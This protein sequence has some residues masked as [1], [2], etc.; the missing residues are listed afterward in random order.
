MEHIVIEPLMHWMCQC[1]F[2]SVHVLD[3]AVYHVAEIWTKIYTAIVQFPCDSMALVLFYYCLVK[4][5]AKSY[6]LMAMC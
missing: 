2:T 3:N 1:T 6:G 5:W 4:M